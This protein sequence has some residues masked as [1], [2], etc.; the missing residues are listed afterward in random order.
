MV[1]GDPA[2]ALTFQEETRRFQAQ[3][4]KRVLEAEDWNVSAAA[5]RL[6]LTRAHLYNLI[7][8]FGLQR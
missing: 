6:D 4:V 3:L 7:K 2:E 1:Q 8:S 5:R